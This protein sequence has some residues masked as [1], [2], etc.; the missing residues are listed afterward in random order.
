MI[1]KEQRSAA[2]PSHA[3]PLVNIAYCDLCSAREEPESAVFDCDHG[4]RW[5]PKGNTIAET[6]ISCVTGQWERKDGSSGRV[7]HIDFHLCVQCFATKL[8]PWMA[9]QGAKPSVLRCNTWN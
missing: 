1:K 3:T 4:V 8:V 9:Q 5:I 7:K 2:H 6:H